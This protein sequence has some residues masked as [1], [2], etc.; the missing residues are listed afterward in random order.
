MRDNVGCD[1]FFFFENWSFD[2]IE[3][4]KER[5]SICNYSFSSVLM[6]AINKPINQ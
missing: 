5:S 1:F 6:A 4:K 3:M 2:H